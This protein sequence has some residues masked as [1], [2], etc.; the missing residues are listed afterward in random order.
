MSDDNVTLE[1][2]K[3]QKEQESILLHRY[4]RLVTAFENIYELKTSFTLAELKERQSTI[5]NY[6]R[7]IKG[8]IKKLHEAYTIRLEYEARYA[9]QGEK[10]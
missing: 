3:K 7:L 10:I 2:I 4:N 1:D 5:S 8:N 9:R 6:V